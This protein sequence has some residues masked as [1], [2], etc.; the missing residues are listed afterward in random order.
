MLSTTRVADLGG[1]GAE[2]ADDVAAGV[3][4]ER[5]A[6]GDAAQVRLVLRLDARHADLAALGVA[7]VGVGGQV[8]RRDVARRSRGSGCRSSR[9]GG[10]CAARRSATLTPG[11]LG[12]VRLEELHGGRRDAG[13][14]GH[15]LVRAVLVVVDGRLH[16]LRR[17]ADQ[18]GHHAR[19]CRGSAPPR[20]ATAG[21][22]PAG[23]LDTSTVPLRSTISPRGRRD[24]D[25]AH[26]VARHRGGVASCPRPPGASTGAGPGR[27]R[28][29]STMTPTMRSRRFGRDS[30]SSGEPTMDATL[31]LLRGRMRGWRASSR[32]ERRVAPGRVE[33]LGWSRSPRMGW[34][35][36]RFTRACSR[37]GAETSERRLALP[38]QGPA[39]Q[40]VDR[41]HQHD[42]RDARPPR[43]RARKSI[44]TICSCPRIAPSTANSM[45][46][47]TLP[48]SA[49]TGLSQ[50]ARGSTAAVSEPD[51]EAEQAPDQGGQ[52]EGRGQDE[53]E[54]EPGPESDDGPRLGP[55]EQRR[56]DRAAATGGRGGPRRCA[57]PPSPSAGPSGRRRSRRPPGRMDAGRSRRRRPLHDVD[58]GQLAQVGRRV[59]RRCSP[60]SRPAA[61]WK[62]RT[63]ATGI[64]GGKAAACEPAGEHDLALVQRRVRRHQVGGHGVARALAVDDAGVAGSAE[65][66]ADLGL[67]VGDQADD[68]GVVEATGSPARPARRRRRPGCRRRPRRRGPCRA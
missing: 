33:G 50:A 17:L 59:D 35:R 47:A 11:V 52:P 49:A 27:R 58:V 7:L 66:H 42:A 22:P 37:P 36:V 8:A 39:H 45:S 63:V 15:R 46:A 28:G 1:G 5:L 68:R 65:G 4:R 56:R 19:R 62:D 67:A 40:P 20:P 31:T 61:V 25:D 51:G 16:L 32:H 54:G 30:S 23:V 2:R 10:R 60:G 29:R 6:P 12:L 21:S 43:T 18:R 3:D 13:R 9:P 24:A 55:V 57:V 26:L 48:A 14:D 44:C 53:V 64:P 41:E 34:R 38:G